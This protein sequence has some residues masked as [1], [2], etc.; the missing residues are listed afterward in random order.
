MREHRA[1]ERRPQALALGQLAA[2]A[3]QRVRARRSGPGRTAFAKRPTENAEN[4]SMLLGCGGGI[5]C[6][7]TVR[8]A[9]ARATTEARLRPTATATHCQRTTVNAS[10][11][12]VKLGPRHQ[13]STATTPM[14]MIATAKRVAFERG[15]RLSRLLQL[16]AATALVDLEETAPDRV[17]GVPLL[18]EAAARRRPSPAGAARRRAAP[19]R[20]P[21]APARR[22]QGTTQRS[23][24]S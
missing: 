7:M 2:R 5:A 11:I 17:P 4:T 20:R 21:R 3:P 24:A 6:R 22:P 13:R 15:N 14:K 16:H 1:D 8:H 18:R 23:R 10:P 9:I 19:R 12:A